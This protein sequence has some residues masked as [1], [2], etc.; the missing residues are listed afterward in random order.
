MCY[1]KYYGREEGWGGGGYIKAAGGKLKSKGAWDK[2]KGG[3][4]KKDGNYTKTK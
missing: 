4:R 1:K 2:W 3:K